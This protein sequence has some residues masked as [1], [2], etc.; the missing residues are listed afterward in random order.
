MPSRSRSR[1]SATGKLHSFYM[2]EAIFPLNMD[3]KYYKNKVKSTAKNYGIVLRGN[4]MASHYGEHDNVLLGIV[5]AK[6]INDVN[7]W[8]KSN[9]FLTKTN[10]RHMSKKDAKWI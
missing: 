1:K 4:G 8:L 7:Q 3:L 6:S 9:K 10:V 5:K 2:F